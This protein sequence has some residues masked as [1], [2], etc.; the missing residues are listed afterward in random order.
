MEQLLNT[1]A[2]V[3][4][5]LAGNAVTPFNV[6]D[7][8]EEQALNA[9]AGDVLSDPTPRASVGPRPAYRWGRA[10]SEINFNFDYEGKTH[11]KEARSSHLQ[12][13][14]ETNDRSHREQR[15]RITARPRSQC[16]A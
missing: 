9:T 3:A 14:D 13:R 15:P 4:S 11:Q 2:G 7:V 10:Q 16:Q 6:V 1:A 5:Y 12:Q 8:E